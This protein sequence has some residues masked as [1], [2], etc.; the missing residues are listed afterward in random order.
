MYN[1]LIKVKIKFRKILNPKEGRKEAE[2]TDG[3]NKNK[4]QKK[5]LIMK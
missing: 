5:D 2:R 1:N 3:T 4:K